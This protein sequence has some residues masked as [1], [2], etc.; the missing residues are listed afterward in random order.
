MLCPMLGKLNAVLQRCSGDLQYCR[1]QGLWLF[2][3]EGVQRV[4]T[5]LYVICE[6]SSNIASNLTPRG[7]RLIYSYYSQPVLWCGFNRTSQSTGSKGLVGD[8]ASLMLVGRM[9]ARCYLYRIDQTYKAFRSSFFGLVQRVH[10]CF[11]VRQHRSQCWNSSQ[12][13]SMPM[14]IGEYE[15]TPDMP[16]KCWYRAKEVLLLTRR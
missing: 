10:I 4:S 7:L 12:A 1:Q 5:D 3:P 9:L 14:S 11:G 6:A 8:A 2:V 16:S 13:D 15:P